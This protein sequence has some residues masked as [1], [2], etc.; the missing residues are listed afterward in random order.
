MYFGIRYAT[1]RLNSDPDLAGMIITGTNDVFIPGGD[2]GNGSGTPGQ[3]N[4]TWIDFSTLAGDITP[5]DM[6]RQSAKPV[7]SAVNGICQGGGFMIAL[8]SDATVVSERA[9]FRVPELF[10]G[11]AD[12]YYAQLLPRI[13]GIVRTRDLMLTGRVLTAEE[14]LDWGLVTRVVPHDEVVSAAVELLGQ[15]CRT[16]PDARLQMKRVLDGYV[17]LHDRIG[18]ASSNRGPERIEGFRAFKERRSPEWVPT[19]LHQNGRL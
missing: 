17:G 11:I 6:L 8:C 15:I 19:E 13:V 3:P 16:A 4:D 5:F 14:A 10:R 7:V 1:A 18:M 12:L 9:T 2:L